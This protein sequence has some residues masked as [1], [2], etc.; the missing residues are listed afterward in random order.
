MMKI[1][2]KV[3]T[4]NK[5]K[6]I[7]KELLEFVRFNE[8]YRYCGGGLYQIQRNTRSVRKYNEYL[9]TTT[10]QLDQLSERVLL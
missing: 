4:L 1:R 5:K 3:S 2:G 7:R 6:L 9:E 8:K 10:N